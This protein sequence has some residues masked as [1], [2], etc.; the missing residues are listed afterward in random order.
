[1]DND[2]EGIVMES[3]ELLLFDEN[4]RRIAS[5]SSKCRDAEKARQM[6]FSVTQ[7]TPYA[8][9]E[10]W[11]GATKIAEGCRFIIWDE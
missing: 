6:I 1:M 3:Y 9:F 10:V 8:R 5:Y 4:G 7:E 11:T 2:V